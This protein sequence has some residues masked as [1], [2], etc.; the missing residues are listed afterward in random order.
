MNA[1]AALTR[2]FALD[3]LSISWSVKCGDLQFEK[4]EY[5]ASIPDPDTG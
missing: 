4:G 3:K 2:N 1:I 5:Y